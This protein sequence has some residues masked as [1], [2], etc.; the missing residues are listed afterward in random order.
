[1]PTNENIYAELEKNIENMVNETAETKNW[2]LAKYIPPIEESF[3]KLGYRENSPGGMENILIVKLDNVGDFVL[4]SAAIREIRKNFPAANITLVVTRTVF[5]IAER[6]PY[7]NEIL[8]FDMP[9]DV[10]NIDQLLQTVSVFCKNFLWRRRF[11]LALDLRYFSHGKFHNM[12]MCFLSGARERKG[13][14]LGMENYYKDEHWLEK[15]NF[16]NYFLNRLY[17]HPKEII[18]DA[19]RS[20]FLISACG[21]KIENTELELW[22]DSEDKFKAKKLLENFLEKKLKIIVGLGASG[23][24]RRYPVEKYLEAFKKILEKNNS[25]VFI[26][27]GGSFEEE[28]AKILQENLPEESVLNLAEKNID[29]RTCAAVV[30]HGDLYIGNDTGVM[31]LAAAEKIPVIYLSRVAKDRKEH[32]PNEPTESEIYFPYRTK[33]ILLQP[34]HQLDD[35]AEKEFFAGCSSNEV[36]CISQIEPEEIVSAFDAMEIFLQ[37]E[38]KEIKIPST[39]RQQDQIETI[40]SQKPIQG[41]EFQKI[42]SD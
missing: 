35:C 13:Y 33:T 5:P 7:V 17:L 9:F 37:S 34:E 30:S 8:P 20:L 16:S 3:Q 42:N 4:S 41:I 18:H 28:N 19:A 32:F 12:C 25:A 40:L 14:L 10:T 23:Y 36:H 26:L 15:P 39:I 11:D 31:H 38:I 27:L 22:Y 21:L 1:M 24:P 6:C 2:D 29:W